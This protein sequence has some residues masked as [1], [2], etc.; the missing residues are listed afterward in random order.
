MTYASALTAVIARLTAAG[1]KECRS[2]NGLS[3]AGAPRGHQSFAVLPAGDRKEKS[4]GAARTDGLRTTARF[5]VELGHEL[6]PG[7]G[8]AAAG[9]ALTDLHTA[10]RYLVQPGTTLTTTA[11]V[12]LGNVSARR[13]GGGSYMIQTFECGVTFSLDLS[14]P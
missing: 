2:P 11:A 7:S 12:Q 3:G 4:R 13:L 6:K 1:L 9:Q 14:A 10:Q 8:L 5:S